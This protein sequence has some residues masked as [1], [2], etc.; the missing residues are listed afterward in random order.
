[1]TDRGKAMAA[2]RKRAGLTQEQLAL[3]SGL[4]R[5]TIARLECR[6]RNGRIDTIEILADALGISLDEYVG[7]SVPN[8]ADV[9]EV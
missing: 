4:P 5:V 6:D 9:C 8:G 7:R 1:M 3:L 2:A